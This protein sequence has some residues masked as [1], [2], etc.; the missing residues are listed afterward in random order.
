MKI[1]P[2]ASFIQFVYPFLFPASEFSARCEKVERARWPGPTE[3]L[4]VWGKGKFPEDDLLFHVARYLNAS[5]G[6]TSTEGLPYWAAALCGFGGG[7][8]LALLALR[9]LRK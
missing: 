9:Q 2:D 4:V 3:P 8:I 7:I 6:L 1:D 5:D